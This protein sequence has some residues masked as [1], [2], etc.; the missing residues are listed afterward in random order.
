MPVVYQQAAV[1]NKGRRPV[2]KKVLYAAA[3]KD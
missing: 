3:E 1:S 2:R